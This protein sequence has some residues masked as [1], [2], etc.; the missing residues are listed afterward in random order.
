MI[1]APDMISFGSVVDPAQRPGDIITIERPLSIPAG[2]EKH[3]LDQVTIPLG[4]E[5]EMSGADP[6]RADPD[7]RLMADDRL[8]SN[9]LA[10]L[11]RLEESCGAAAS[12]RR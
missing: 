5:G 9:I 7:H 4:A 1:G 2:T 3:I 11:Q 10:R 12:R 6:R 8:L